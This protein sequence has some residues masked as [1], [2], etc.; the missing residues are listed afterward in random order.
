MDFVCDWI[1]GVIECSSDAICNAFVSQ[2]SVCTFNVDI[3]TIF[4]PYAC[5]SELCIYIRIIYIYIYI[6]IGRQ[7]TDD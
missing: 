6:Y 2:F 7:C 4:V 3:P 1:R 5:A